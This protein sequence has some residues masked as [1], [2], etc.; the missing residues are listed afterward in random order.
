MQF[1]EQLYQAEELHQAAP[2]RDFEL[3]I[4]IGY[5]KTATSWFQEKIIPNPASGFV[6]PWDN[7]AGRVTDAF[8]LAN[9]FDEDVN[10]ARGIFE[11]GLRHCDGKPGIPIISREA[12]CGQP[13][14]QIYNGRYVADRLHAAFPSAKILIGIRE[15]RALAVSLYRT[16]V[17][18][19]GVFPLEVFI[20]RGTEPPGFVPILRPDYLEY[21]RIVGYYQNL[22][23]REN[24]LVMPIEFLQK[25]PRKY[26]QTVFD[27]C[28]S[29]G[30]IDKPPAAAEVGNSAF[31]LEIRRRLN[32]LVPL[33]PLTHP[34]ATRKQRAMHKLINL[35]DRFAPRSWS[36]PME[37]R[38]KAIAAQRYAGMFRDSNR[39]LAEL[40]EIDL[41]ALGYDV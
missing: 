19:A 27:F 10:R 35:I 1:Q 6:V 4:H 11:E 40:T 8:C 12:L 16:Y 20:G 38:W 2:H 32:P 22:Y 26:L 13:L 21:D 34:F 37:R 17:K 23:G 33:N 30:K 24:V 9:C 18:L 5:P 28:Q 41:G 15:Q 39:R 29:A 25:D 36:E 14:N 31:A 7:A 3:V